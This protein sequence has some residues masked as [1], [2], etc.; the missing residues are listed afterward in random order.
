MKNLIALTFLFLAG[1]AQAADTIEA[2]VLKAVVAKAGQIVIVDAETRQPFPTEM[3]L[4]SMI[5][6]ALTSSSYLGWKNGA[7][8]LYGVS[9]RCENVTR[10][11][12]VGS[13]RYE[14]S[15]L[16][17][18]G[19]FNVRTGSRGTTFTGPN[20]ESSVSFKVIVVEPVVPNPQPVIENLVV[21]GWLAG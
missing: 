6:S 5:A 17:N 3:Q 10:P 18:D 14:C 9:V 1:Q 21:E 11:G 7:T 4:P 16:I 8:V 15:V 2:R 12:L 13:S 20:L 19:D